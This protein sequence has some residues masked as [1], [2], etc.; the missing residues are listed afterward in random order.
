MENREYKQG[1]V[2]SRRQLLLGVSAGLVTLVAHP[3]LAFVPKAT[4][5]INLL[6]THT[7]EKL[8]ITYWADGKYISGALGE[9][10]H[11]LRDHRTG[12]VHP[13]DPKLIDKIALI[14]QNMESSKPYEV[15]SG[16]RSPKSNSLLREKS[17]G[18][19]K[20]SLHLQGKAI[21]I[22][23]PGREL[24]SLRDAALALNSGGVGFYRGSNFVHIDTGH[25]RRW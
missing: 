16:F 7:G 12:D 9:I 23:L 19:A 13:I 3:A 15:I 20:G 5:S 25:T 2:I 1:V 18:V 22:R 17:K 14:H 8:A 10:D 11:V 21:D 4:R 6:N 24:S